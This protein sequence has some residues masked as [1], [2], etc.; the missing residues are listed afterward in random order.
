MRFLDH[1][2]IRIKM[3]LAAL[4]MVLLALC[5]GVFGYYNTKTSTELVDQ[6]Y[7]AQLMPNDYL[8]KR[9]PGIRKTAK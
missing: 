2:K 9:Q 1:L 4:V 5:V 7:S 3:M 6:L 8:G